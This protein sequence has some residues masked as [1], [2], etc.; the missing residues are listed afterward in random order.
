MLVESNCDDPIDHHVMERVIKVQ[1][2]EKHAKHWTD[3]D[4][5]VF[6]SFMWWLGPNMT[7][8]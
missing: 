4:M 2:I 1:K 6:D 8:L 3:A 7:L 5:L